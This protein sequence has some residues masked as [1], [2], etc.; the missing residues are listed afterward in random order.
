MDD[1]SNYYKPDNY[2]KE[3]LARNICEKVLKSGKRFPID[4]AQ[5]SLILKQQGLEYSDYGYSRCKDLFL[6]LPDFFEVSH[7]IP[8][9]MVIGLTPKMQ[10][11]LSLCARDNGPNSLGNVTT[12]PIYNVMHTLRIPEEAHSVQLQQEDVQHLDIQQNP[13]IIF[14]QDQ[15]KQGNIQQ[16]RLSTERPTAF[17]MAQQ[18]QAHYFKN[19]TQSYVAQQPANISLRQPLGASLNPVFQKKRDILQE[20]FSHSVAEQKLFVKTLNKCVYMRN[21]DTIAANLLLLTRVDS[22]SVTG[23]INVLAFSYVLAMKEGRIVESRDGMYMC[24]DILMTD[25]HGE[26]IYFLAE[27]NRFPGTNWILKGITKKSSRVLGQI[28]QNIFLL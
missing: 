2:S 28:I 17:S 1:Y 26:S 12:Q 9:K 16:S 19:Q 23:W 5:L 18:P 22:L 14:G 3:V 21:K 10:E 24:F 4:V 20:F 25:I 8:T 27:K 15:P 6:S 13:E 11:I 7:P